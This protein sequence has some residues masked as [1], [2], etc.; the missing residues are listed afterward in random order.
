[1]DLAGEK[2]TP[3]EALSRLLERLERVP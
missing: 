1:V 3:H 2:G